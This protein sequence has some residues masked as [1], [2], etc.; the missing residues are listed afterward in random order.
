MKKVGPLALLIFIVF[1]C[2]KELDF[3]MINDIE[4]KSSATV[5]LANLTLSIED[6]VSDIEDSTLVVD[7][8]NALRIFYRQDSVF[9]YSI[10]DILTY[11][12]SF[13]NH[14]ANV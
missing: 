12:T 6:L 13:S 1:A 7:P 14:V 5:P 4:V 10:D 8:S 11:D 3:D 9:T 2:N